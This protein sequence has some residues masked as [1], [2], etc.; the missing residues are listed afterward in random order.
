M[1]AQIKEAEARLESMKSSQK[2]N[3][4]KAMA[5]VAG[6]SDGALKDMIF[7]EWLKFYAEAK[8]DKELNS[9]VKEAEKRLKEFQ[10]KSKE[11]QKDVLKKMSASTDS[12]LVASVFTSW[13]EEVH[14]AKKAKHAEDQINGANSKFAMLKSRNKDASTGRAQSANELEDS[15]L[16]M[17]IFMN[18]STH[19]RINSLVDHYG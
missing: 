10:A 6:G 12:G 7:K 8:R 17:Q 2:E 19:S 11:G 14:H 3:A 16:M 15:I 1:D 5:K 9:Q 18:W 13:C 4:K